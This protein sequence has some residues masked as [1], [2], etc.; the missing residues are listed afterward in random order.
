MLLASFEVPQ[1]GSLVHRP[2]R[3]ETLMRVEGHSYDLILMPSKGVKQFAS[4]CIPQ[5]GRSIKATSD[6]LVAKWG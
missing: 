3:T 4:I 6:Y 2:S 1:F 5:F